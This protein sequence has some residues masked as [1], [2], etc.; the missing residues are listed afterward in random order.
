MESTIFQLM[1][2]HS[3]HKHADFLT[4]NIIYI[5]H[6]KKASLKEQSST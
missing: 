4:W 3:I 2:E 1:V 6:L 5:P